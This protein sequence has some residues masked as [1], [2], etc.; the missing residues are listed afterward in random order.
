M[1]EMQEPAPYIG[2][3]LKKHRLVKGMR[4]EELCEGICSV[5][6]LSKIENGK[7]QIK[8]E[9][10]KVMAQR[11]GVSMELLM[12]TD[13]IRDELHEGIER[14]K[15]ATVAN[16]Y[17]QALSLIR[18]V[19]DRAK[20]CGYQDLYA[21]AVLHE[22]YL[23]NMT[24]R[25]YHAALGK[26]QE[27]L[28]DAEEFD[29]IT[30]AD[31]LIEYGR[32]HAFTGNLAEA[33]RHYQ[34][35]D[36]ILQEVEPIQADLYAR[37]LYR[38][39]DCMFYMHNWRAGYRYADQSARL[40]ERLGK[41]QY[42]VRSLSVQ[43]AFA[44]KLGR[45][46]EAKQLIERLLHEARNN[47]LIHEIGTLEN[48]L[49]CWYLEQGDLHNAY[50]H[51]QSS[52]NSFELLNNQY[53]LCQPLMNLAEWALKSGDAELS[54]QYVT[55]VAELVQS[56]NLLGLHYLF[57]GRLLTLTAEMFEM[58]GEE[59][60]ML[61]A[62]EQALDLYDRNRAIIPGYEVCVILADLCYQRQDPRALPLYKQAVRYHRMMQELGV[63]K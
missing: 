14:A 27:I 49:G 53:V 40:A 2:E 12:A 35:A 38:I 19:S 3:N 55:K 57:E 32:A 29:P 54:R 30:R 45:P 48:N 31:L 7:A 36:S 1:F 18:S 8:A 6:Q 25:K 17:P 16:A 15:K 56:G 23:L 11:L 10:L 22:C 33:F 39:S 28:A 58:L 42:R 44:N 5:S 43:A 63:K 13:A 26:L 46:E 51:L 62:Y 50:R 61:G 41:H 9:Q 60:Q 34:H 20:E 4:Q 37:V 59:E 47:D 24:E 52:M 21:E